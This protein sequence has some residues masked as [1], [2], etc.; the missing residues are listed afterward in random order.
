MA[1][2]VAALVKKQESCEEIIKDFV[3]KTEKLVKVVGE[4]F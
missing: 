2:Q 1:G 4:Y 3:E